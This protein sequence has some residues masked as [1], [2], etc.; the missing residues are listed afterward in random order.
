VEVGVS[1]DSFKLVYE[2]IA[3]IPAYKTRVSRDNVL[4][5]LFKGN[6][7]A[8]SFLGEIIS[9]LCKFL[10]SLCLIFFNFISTVNRLHQRLLTCSSGVV[11]IKM[12][13]LGETSSG[14]DQTALLGGYVMSAIEH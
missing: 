9:I 4:T 11:P 7:S 2:A 6:F 8:N 10:I 5:K 12:L 1:I 13:R 14:L 3:K